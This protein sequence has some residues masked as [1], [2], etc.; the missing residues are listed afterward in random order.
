MT[1][2]VVGPDEK[3]RS[4]AYFQSQSPDYHRSVETGLLRHLRERERR[5]IQD[6]ADLGDVLVK[7]MI[8]VGCGTGVHAL[9]GRAAG[10]HVTAVD[11][12]PW[13]VERLRGRVDV[14]RVGDV[15][16]PIPGTFDVV[17]CAGVLDYVADP[18]AALGNLCRLVG[19]GGRLVIQAPRVGV[20]G[21]VHAYIVRRKHGLRVNLFRVGWLERE[22]RRHQLQLS[23]WRYP[24]P[25]NVVAV[26]TR[27]GPSGRASARK[28]PA[29]Q[30]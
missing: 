29:C 10:L 27:R 24:L 30:A 15:E 2:F 26:C 23:R 7:T 18:S 14:A 17:V 11:I 1:A 22:A 20:G 25:H 3:Q 28:S 13:A 4:I 5:V 6:F 21:W 19:P 12:S 16:Q 9:A 8:D